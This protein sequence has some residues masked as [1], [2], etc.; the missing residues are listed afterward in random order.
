VPFNAA[1]QTTDYATHA[2]PLALQAP[3]A[4]TSVVISLESGE[5]TGLVVPERAHPN[6][7]P[8]TKAK[9]VMRDPSIT[10]LAFKFQNEDGDWVD[11]WD[12]QE[13]KAIPRGV[14]LR[15]GSTLNGRTQTLPPLT[16]TLRATGA[17][18]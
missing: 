11:T 4:F 2:P 5:D 18:R 6:R 3:I 15:L 17:A 8:L 13:L 10:S 1:E 16:V 9:I 7:D 14:Q 12:G